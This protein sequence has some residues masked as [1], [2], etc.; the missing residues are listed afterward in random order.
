MPPGSVAIS[1]WRL[2]TA[3]GKLAKG[4][5]GED[6]ALTFFFASP[7]LG[8]R[9]WG[10]NPVCD[11]GSVCGRLG[12]ALSAAAELGALKAGTGPQGSIHPR[13]AYEDGSVSWLIQ[14]FVNS[15]SE[16]QCESMESM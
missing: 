1:A 8:S 9:V 12:G 5:K 15:G 3:A 6:S 14:F 4:L 13:S 2:G 7:G 16:N 10:F 11:L